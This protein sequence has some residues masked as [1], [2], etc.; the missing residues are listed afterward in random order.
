M[1]GRKQ[2]ACKIEI[3]LK[4]IAVATRAKGMMVI[5]EVEEVSFSLCW[6]NNFPYNCLEF[7]IFYVSIKLFPVQIQFGM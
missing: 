3:F 1:T 6:L 4:A 7:N 5:L 2:G